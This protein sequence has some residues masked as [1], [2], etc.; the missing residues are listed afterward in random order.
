MHDTVAT[1]TLS[2][3]EELSAGTHR[4]NWLSTEQVF[5]I[6]NNRNSSECKHKWVKTKLK[7]Y[8]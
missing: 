5:Y 7:C 8:I 1:Y 6:E 4:T 2:T 3:A